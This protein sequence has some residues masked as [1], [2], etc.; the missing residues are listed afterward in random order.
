[1]GMPA[2]VVKC[3]GGPY[4]GQYMF[5]KIGTGNQT[6]L[7]DNNGEKGR[8]RIVHGFNRSS[9]WEPQNG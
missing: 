6:L 1:M 4:N 3:F 2:Y 7:L 8:Y 9:K 5:T